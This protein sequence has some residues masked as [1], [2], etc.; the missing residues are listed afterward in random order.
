L[1]G[2]S[3]EVV[4][5]C[6]QPTIGHSAILGR[7]VLV[8]LLA[9]WISGRAGSKSRGP[10]AAAFAAAPTAAGVAA[11]GALGLFIRREALREALDESGLATS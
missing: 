6:I 5:D 8:L 3:L 4:K 2:L 10:A 7:L 9:Q 11:L 1:N